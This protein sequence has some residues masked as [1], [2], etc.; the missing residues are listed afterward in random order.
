M[1]S[2]RSNSVVHAFALKHDNGYFLSLILLPSL[3]LN[4]NLNYST[5][6]NR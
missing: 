5:K 6:L 2:A 4:F 3:L 1:L